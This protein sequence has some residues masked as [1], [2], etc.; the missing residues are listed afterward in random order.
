MGHDLTPSGRLNQI[1][2][3]VIGWLVQKPA[4]VSAV[5]FVASFALYASTMAPGLTWA[6]L[7]GDGGDFLAAAHTWGIPHPTGYPTYL[8]LLRG[9]NSATWFGD[10]ASNGNLFSAVAGAAAVAVLFLA[11]RKMLLRLPVSETRGRILQH[12]TA[13]I[14]AL[15]FATFNIHWSQ[16]TITE[17]YTLN[18]LFVGLFLW[19]AVLARTRVERSEPSL[20]LRAGMAFL[21]GVA[22]GNHVTIVFVV[23]PFG[24]WVY[25]PLLQPGRRFALLR[26]WQTATCLLVGLCVYLYAPIASSQDPPINWFFPDTLSGFQTMITGKPYQ[27]YL[28][29]VE[30]D[31]LRDRIPYLADRWLT[32]YTALGAIFGLVGL[33]VLWNRLRGFTVAG[34]VSVVSL[35]VYSVT[36]RGF[37]SYVLLV[38][39]F[40]VVGTWIAAGILNLVV[41]LLGFA[42]RVDGTWLSAYRSAITPV[43]L[44]IAIVGVPVWSL[45][46]NY[47]GI[48][49][50][51]DAEAV[52]FVSGAFEAAGPGSVIIAEDIPTF[53]LWYQALV[54]EP[55][56][57][58]AVV[59][60]FL[61]GQD[62]YWEHLQRQ[63]PGR[64]PQEAIIGGTRQLRAIVSNNRGKTA[65]LFTRENASYSEIYGLEAVGP[66]WR[67]KH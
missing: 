21:M 14:A 17:V 48:D 6:N 7:G 19:L 46:F 9:F 18:A 67:V 49:I 54:A 39:V 12:V 38:P 50:S 42:E 36:Y 59:A 40:M 26:E 20:L 53:A 35:T 3:A 23:I 24:L 29:G 22:L 66:L 64:I 52:E 62:W 16:S 44:L 43:V 34:I 33:T 58:V 41:S 45:I 5:L 4:G 37:D 15:G 25:W 63:F 51:D 10:A 56:Q 27:S 47:S 13:F 55:D 11:T 30:G 32:Q 31:V 8:V 2:N 1:S 60:W 28:F 57:D 65:V 61:L